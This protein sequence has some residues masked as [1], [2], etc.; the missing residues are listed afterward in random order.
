MSHPFSSATMSHY[1]FPVFVQKPK[2]EME[3]GNKEEV[4]A[5]ECKI[6]PGKD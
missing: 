2:M 1:V 6:H 3:C 5:G 4:K